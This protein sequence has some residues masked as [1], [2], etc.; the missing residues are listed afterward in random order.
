[1][2]NPINRGNNAA[3][4]IARRGTYNRAESRPLASNVIND[5]VIIQ[6]HCAPSVVCCYLKREKDS[7]LASFSL[8]RYIGNYIATH[9]RPLCR[10]EGHAAVGKIVRPTIRSAMKE[11]HAR[12]CSSFSENTRLVSSSSVTSTTSRR[13]AGCVGRFGRTDGRTDE[14]QKRDLIRAHTAREKE[15]GEEEVGVSDGRGE[16]PVKACGSGMNERTGETE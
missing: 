16:L 10:R 4:L 2:R 6:S 7:H 12:S 9:T 15:E 1:M 5:Y 11:G 3:G 14:R 13:R 8:A